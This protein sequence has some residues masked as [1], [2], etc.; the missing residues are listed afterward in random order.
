[1]KKS[2]TLLPVGLDGKGGLSAAKKK[3]VQYSKIHKNLQV[4][5]YL[6]K[7]QSDGSGQQNLAFLAKLVLLL[8]VCTLHEVWALPLHLPTGIAMAPTF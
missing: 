3:M 4:T 2:I 1:V 5:N 6:E 8:Q 7:Q